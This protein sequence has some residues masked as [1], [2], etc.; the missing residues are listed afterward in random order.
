MTLWTNSKIQDPKFEECHVFYQDIASPGRITF[1]QLRAFRRFGPSRIVES[2]KHKKGGLHHLVCNRWCNPS[3]IM[4]KNCICFP[5]T[6]LSAI[7]HWLPYCSPKSKESKTKGACHISFAPL[8][9][10][11]R[12]HL[13]ITRMVRRL[14]E[15]SYETLLF[16]GD[17]RTGTL[18]ASWRG[19]IG[20][21]CFSDYI[22]FSVNFPIPARTL[23][24]PL[25]NTILNAKKRDFWT[26]NRKYSTGN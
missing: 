23:N 18:R 14:L 5:D 26:D 13:T 10:N 11:F 6:E 7:E 22:S 4:I 8:T 25:N 15:K 16:W 12:P 9:G 20:S 3:Q 21:Q 2:G 24:C 17:R 1:C 19:F